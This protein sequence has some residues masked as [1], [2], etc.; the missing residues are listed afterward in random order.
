M[1]LEKHLDPR[2]EKHIIAKRDFSIK[3]IAARKLNLHS[4][5]NRNNYLY[6]PFQSNSNDTFNS[7]HLSGKETFPTPWCVM[8]KNQ[9]LLSRVFSPLHFFFW[10][11]RLYGL[12]LHLPLKLRSSMLMILA[13]CYYTANFKQTFCNS[14]PV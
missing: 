11:K 3:H 9:G 13:S 7:C 5:S 14:L 10:E 1:T 12:L 8:L 2:N 6:C 4:N